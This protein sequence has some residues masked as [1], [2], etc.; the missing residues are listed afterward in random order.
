MQ[1]KTFRV[2]IV[3][4]TVGWVILEDWITTL[5]SN[6]KQSCSR[7]WHLLLFFVSSLPEITKTPSMVFKSF[8]WHGWHHKR[9]VYSK[10]TEAKQLARQVIE[11]ILLLLIDATTFALASV[12]T[13]PSFMDG[14]ER[15]PTAWTR[16]E[17]RKVNCHM[18]KIIIF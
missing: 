8:S 1:L 3:Y 7:K 2:H 14:T 6:G 15:E 17:L 12:C 9:T 10:S 16:A 18:L 11:Q 5:W 4:N 13:H